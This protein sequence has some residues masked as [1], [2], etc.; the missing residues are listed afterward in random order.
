MDVVTENADEPK[1]DVPLKLIAPGE[2]SSVTLKMSEYAFAPLLLNVTVEPVP[3][4][5]I[6][7]VEYRVSPDAFNVRLVEPNAEKSPVLT[8]PPFVK[9]VSIENVYVVPFEMTAKSSFAA[10][11]IVSV[12]PPPSETAANSV[13]CSSSSANAAD[14]TGM[15]WPIRRF[16][17]RPVNRVFNRFNHLSIRIIV[18]TPTTCFDSTIRQCRAILRQPST[19]SLPRNTTF[20]EFSLGAMQRDGACGFWGSNPGALTD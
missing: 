16:V 18:T 14:R 19:R 15:D 20:D 4:S 3:E 10:S 1:S 9:L 7:I 5:T 8:T 2:L 17:V 13:R 12:L 6:A 11:E